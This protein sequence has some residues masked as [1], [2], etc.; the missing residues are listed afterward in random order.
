[1]NISTKGRYASRAMLELAMR[2]SPEPVPLKTIA[3]SQRISLKYL[4][5]I[6]TSLA[7]EGLVISVRGKSGGYLLAR[8]A[9]KITLDEIVKTV[10]GDMAPVSCV[11][12]A[13]LC[14]RSAVCVTRDIWREVEDT[15]LGV[16]RSY[17]LA[18]LM[19]REGF[20]RQPDESR[21]APDS[22]PALD[23]NKQRGE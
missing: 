18:H 9:A 3:S 21:D 23:T 19:A 15:V 17:S 1:M 20:A 12:D 13:S 14:G 4:E 11:T 2:N 8:P 22:A 10:E 5:R 16:L 6:M 7:G